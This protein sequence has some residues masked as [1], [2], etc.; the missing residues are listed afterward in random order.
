MNGF[1][2][3]D[4]FLLQIGFIGYGEYLQSDL[5]A[6]IVSRLNQLEIT[7]SCERCG[8]KFGLV[9]HHR[10]Y[11]PE[12]LVGN[13]TMHD[14]N[15]KLCDVIADANPLIRLC[16]SCHHF[17]HFDKSWRWIE[18]MEDVDSML[19]HGKILDLTWPKSNQ[20]FE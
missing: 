2:T 9:W 7:K 4:E 19:F 3:R 11:S 6:W 20:D 5:W 13:F 14:K 16:T 17:I 18:S 10:T 12:V 8:G 1:E 15:Y